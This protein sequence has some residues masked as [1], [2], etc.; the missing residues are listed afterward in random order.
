[1]PRELPSFVSQPSTIFTHTMDDTRYRVRLTWRA[2]Q[3][4]WYMDIYTQDMTPIAKGRRLSGRSDPLVGV[5]QASQPPGAFLVFGDL[6][7][8]EELGTEDGRLL[9]Y[10]ESEIPDED[11]DDLGLRVTT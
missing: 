9:Y 6:R 10:S 4:A 8:R 2:R 5:L 11:S 7:Q 1:M 3:Q